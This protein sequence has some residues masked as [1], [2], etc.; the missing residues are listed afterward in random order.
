MKR[1]IT[2]CAVI[3]LAAATVSA[4]GVDLTGEYWFGS[5]SAYART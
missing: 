2:I 5:L 1:L 4:E 3:V